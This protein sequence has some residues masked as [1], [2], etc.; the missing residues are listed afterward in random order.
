[1][2]HLNKALLILF[3]VVLLSSCSD[4]KNEIWLN[5][6]GS[7]RIETSLDMASFFP[8]ELMEGMNKAA[9]EEPVFEDMEMDSTIVEEMIAEPESESSNPLE[10]LFGDDFLKDGK[11]SD[12]DTMI[13]F[14]EMMPDSIKE[15]EADKTDLFKKMYLK[16]NANEAK[17]TAI[18]T[19]IFD[20][21]NV[22]EA[23][24]MLIG[25][26]E[27]MNDNKELE[28]AA[29]FKDLVW[30]SD[31]NFV[32]LPLIS[33]PDKL[34]EEAPGGMGEELDGLMGESDS[35]EDKQMK[36][37]MKEMLGKVVTVVHLPG[38]VEFTNEMDAEIEGNTV[39]FRRS[40]IHLME[41]NRSQKVIKW[42]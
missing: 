16:V 35:E 8:R 21:K 33:P 26:A 38:P 24:Q 6:D 12:L 5:E 28:E 40:I 37:M 29:G 32:K 42:K 9:E 11:I 27:S 4:I 36:E 10:A 18:S 19:F 15:R 30:N 22:E 2:N 39:T 41:K 23:N 14:Y 1:M 17:G 7:G 13:T 31:I 3:S 20:F 34:G 25:M